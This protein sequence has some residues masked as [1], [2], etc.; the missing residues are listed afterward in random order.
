MRPG[1]TP[2]T[3]T[4]PRKRNQNDKSGTVVEPSA[5]VFCGKTLAWYRHR[6]VVCLALAMT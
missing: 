4:H 5:K 3:I 2:L 1:L 6:Y